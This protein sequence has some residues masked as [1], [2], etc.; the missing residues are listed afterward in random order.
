MKNKKDIKWKYMK[1]NGELNRNYK[2]SNYGHV[3]NTK[4][5]VPLKQHNMCKKSS[6]NGTD[7]Q[8]VYVKGVLSPVRV[9][10]IVCETFHGT[11]PEGYTQVNHIDEHKNNNV[12]SNLEWSTPSLN[13]LAYCKNNKKLRFA[14]N[15]IVKVKKLLNK[16]M[17]NDGVAQLIGMSD[18]NVS[19]IK[20]GYIHS[21]IKPFTTA[22]QELGIC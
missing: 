8:S 21:H 5:K 15:T 4:T 18:S 9:H 12:P 10:R 11:A 16:G 17:T 6:K 19:E 20:L 3:I 22:Q 14:E 2:V 1:L 13:Q 7:Y